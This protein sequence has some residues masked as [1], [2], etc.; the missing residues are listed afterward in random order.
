MARQRRDGWSWWTEKRG[1]S[2]PARVSQPDAEEAGKQDG[3]YMDEVT[4][5]QGITQ[6][7]RNGLVQK[8]LARNK[9]TLRLGIQS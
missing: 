4:E 3:Q 2:Q 9:P 1:A 7:N 6:I 8:E 5:P